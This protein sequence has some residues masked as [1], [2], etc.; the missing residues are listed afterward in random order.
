MYQHDALYTYLQQLYQVLKTQ[1]EQLTLLEGRMTELNQELN[2][3]KNEKR[4]NIERLEYHFDQLKVEKLEGTLNIGI[5]PSTISDQIDELSIN[6]KD[7]TGG[8]PKGTP[9]HPPKTEPIHRMI[10]KVD[11]YLNEEFANDMARISEQYNVPID[12]DF[13]PMIMEEIKKQIEPRI[14]FYLQQNKSPSDIKN[15]NISEEQ[16]F[17]QTKQDIRLAI[18]NFIRGLPHEQDGV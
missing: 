5:T 18:E 8:I 1:Q 16:I 14:R 6:G 11:Q 12:A 15:Q 3:L 17:A 10:V 13:F 2:Q 4:I 7:I 9:E